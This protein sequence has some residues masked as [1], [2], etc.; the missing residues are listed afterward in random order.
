LSGKNV[1]ISPKSCAASVLLG[2]QDQ[3]RPLQ[4]LDDVGD[5]EGLAGAGDPEQ[6]LIAL[7]R[8][9]GSPG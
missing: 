4:V 3:S 6:D 8:R 1:F 5:R 2:S 9:D 7:D